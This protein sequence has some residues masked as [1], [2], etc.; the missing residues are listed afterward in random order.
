VDHYM[1]DVANMHAARWDG[2]SPVRG[3]AVSESER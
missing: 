3:S 1:W 2:R